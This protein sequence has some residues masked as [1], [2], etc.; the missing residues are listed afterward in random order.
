MKTLLLL[1]LCVVTTNLFSQTIASDKTNASTGI[2]SITTGTNPLY[3]GVTNTIQVKS[4][5][6]VQDDSVIAYKLNFI[7]PV[8]PVQISDNDLPP[9]TCLLIDADQG[10]YHGTLS[11]S[12]QTY[13]CAF[14]QDDF[15]KL[16]TVKII[17]I[18][19]ITANGKGGS[20]PVNISMQSAI[21]NQAKAINAAL[22][23]Q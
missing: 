7:I 14:P 16:S 10:T 18:K 8:L 3:K 13:T 12:P 15:S 17:N 20:I 22:Q 21:S 19:I 6:D 23:K 5:V 2:R 4:E 1:C 11:T 9:N